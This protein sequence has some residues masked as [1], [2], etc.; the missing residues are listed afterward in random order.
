MRSPGDGHVSV[1]HWLA[2][3]VVVCVPILLVVQYRRQRTAVVANTPPNGIGGWLALF[4]VIL[5]VGFLRSLADFV[6]GLPDYWAG[7][8]NEAAHGPLIAVGLL[9]LAGTVAHLWAIVALFRKKRAFRTA[10]A[11]LWLLMLLTQ[12]A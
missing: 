2:T 11:A 1:W 10:C 12:L 8:R 6:Q 3:L 9:A 7:F 5:C 4:A